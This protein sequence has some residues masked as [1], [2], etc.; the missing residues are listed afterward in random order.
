M[1]ANRLRAFRQRL[2]RFRR[3]RA[4]GVSTARLLRTGGVAAM[5]Y[6]QAV[7]GV[8]PSV[9]LRQRRAAAAAAAPAAGVCGQSLD[10][11]LMLA[12][13]YAHGKADPGHAAHLG[14]IGEWAQAVWEQWMPICVR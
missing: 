12:D 10:L 4:A 6:G 5:P 3:L 11:A 1:T 2:P 8:A 9:L 7:M 14:P 13:E